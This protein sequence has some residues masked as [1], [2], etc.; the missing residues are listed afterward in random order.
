MIIA[1]H[2]SNLKYLTE[3]NKNKPS[4]SFENMV[5]LFESHQ[6]QT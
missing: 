6:I 4:I 2:N 5:T 1:I 3:Q